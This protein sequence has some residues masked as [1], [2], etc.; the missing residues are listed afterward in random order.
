MEDF[1]GTIKLFG[2]NF[3]PR[4]WALCNGE[5]LSI[6]Q[7][8][9]LFALLGTTYGGDGSTTFGLPDL[10]GR[11]PI[12]QGQ[13]PGLK[14]RRLGE[15]SGV[16]TNALTAVQLPQHAHGIDFNGQN[17]NANIRIPSFNDNGSLEESGGNILANKANS[18]AP[19]NK[20]DSTLAAFNAPVQGTM[21]TGQIGAS[22]EVNNMQPYLTVNYCI[23]L[24]G[25]FPPRD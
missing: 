24:E 14:D 16:E 6:S 10:R 18:Y 25:L 15:K 12:S 23:C 21:T 11:V 19:A 5:L 13:G 8:A 3:A 2:F 9:A 4:G 1:I 7:N 22:A 20:K 17:I